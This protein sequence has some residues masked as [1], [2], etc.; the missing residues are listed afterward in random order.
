M[1]NIIYIMA[2]QIINAVSEKQIGH[3]SIDDEV[4]ERYGVE[5]SNVQELYNNYR[6]YNRIMQYN[7]KAKV[8]K[9]EARRKSKITYYCELCDKDVR[10]AVKYHHIR[11]MKHLKFK[12]E[13]EKRAKEIEEEQKSNSE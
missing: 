12:V 4:F 9:D 8:D 10:V 13:V 2:E 5:K 7:R 1:N 6:L 11:T 3:E